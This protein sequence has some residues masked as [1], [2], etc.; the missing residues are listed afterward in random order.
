MKSGEVNLLVAWLFDVSDVTERPCYIHTYPNHACLLRRVS[1]RR[2]VAKNTH[3][4][5]FFWTKKIITNFIK[6]RKFFQFFHNK[7]LFFC[8]LRNCVVPH[9]MFPN[10]GS[11][12]GLGITDKFHKRCSI[13]HLKSHLLKLFSKVIYTFRCFCCH[14]GHSVA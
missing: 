7:P 4:K 5:I 2:A 11:N 10:V 6:T 8:L 1:T 13:L 3:T 12:V 14:D 9:S